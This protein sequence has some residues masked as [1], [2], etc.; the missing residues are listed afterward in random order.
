MRVQDPFE[1]LVSV[2]SG[3]EALHRNRT[4]G[5]S[6]ALSDHGLVSSELEDLLRSI[7]SG[8]ILETAE[9]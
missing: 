6:D 9:D 3:F 1:S 5:A 8:I 7:L 2:V 4:M